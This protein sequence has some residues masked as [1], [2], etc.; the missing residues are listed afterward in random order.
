MYHCRMQEQSAAKSTPWLL[1]IHHLPKDPAYLRVKVGRHLSRVGAIPLK[2]SVYV[3]PRTEGA[4]EDFQWVR[5]EI[6]EGGG[7][8]TVAEAELVDGLSDEQVKAKFRATSDAE[9]DQVAD[10]ARALGA[11]LARRRTPR[12]NDDERATLL[13]GVVRLERRL[14]EIGLTNFFGAGKQPVATALVRELR[15]RAEPATPA[16]A[17]SPRL[18]EIRARTWVTRTGIHVDRIASAWLILR[19]IDREARFKYVQPQ[20]YA[21]VHGEL[22][23][24]MFD[25]EYS[26][27]GDKCT[28]EVLIERFALDEA[29]LRAVAEVVHDIDLKESKFGRPETPGVAACIAGLCRAHRSDDERLRRGGELFESLLAHFA[30]KT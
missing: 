18:P 9:Y 5:R 6:L 3:L 2:N 22:R 15:T 24:D 20:G 14:T 21:P 28:F 29:G 16:S 10:E 12:L 11:T 17:P 23:F 4:L 13:A 1:L 30:T 19:H 8:A 26:H 27:E 25:A 7:E